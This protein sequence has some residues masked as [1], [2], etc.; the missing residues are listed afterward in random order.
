MIRFLVVQQQVFDVDLETSQ[1][2]LKLAQ[3]FSHFAI[4]SG[5]TDN[6]R[7]LLGDGPIPP[8]AIQ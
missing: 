4:E 8:L 2:G 5:I 1:L 3:Y 7:F 6:D